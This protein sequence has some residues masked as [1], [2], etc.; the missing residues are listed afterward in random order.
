MSSV[1]ALDDVLPDL[2]AESAE[3]DARVAGLAEWQWRLDTPAS[4]WDIAHQIA[5]LAWTDGLALLSIEDPAA[6]RDRGRRLA[7]DGVAAVDQAA[8]AGAARSGSQL[9]AGWR[10]A[11]SRLAERLPAV[12]DGRKLEWFGPPMSAASM[13]TARLME[14]W[15]HGQDVAA[16]LGQQVRPT[17]RLRHIARLAVRT[18]DFAFRLHDR[19]VP[20]EEFRVELAAPDGSCWTFGPPGAAQRVTGSAV[21]FCLL[22][23][24]RLHR[25]DARL[26]VSGSEAQGWLEIMQVFAGPPGSGRPPAASR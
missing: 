11:R 24:Q 3:L 16:A 13:A 7:V 10:A 23:A 9:L 26:T 1:S 4:G 2:L 12:P 22:A 19:A 21:D 5:H 18:R 25:A 17:A 8:A 14:T 15:A 6:L 20:A